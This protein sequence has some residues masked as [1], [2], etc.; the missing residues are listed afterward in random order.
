MKKAMSALPVISAA[1]ILSAG[2]AVPA[3]CD[4]MK[5]NECAAV[6][7]IDAGASEAVILDKDMIEK[8][9]KVEDVSVL[10]VGWA[11]NFTDEDQDD[12][13]T[14]EP[15]EGKG[16]PQETEIGWEPGTRV[17]YV[18]LMEDGVTEADGYLTFF[19]PVI[20]S[21]LRD[22]SARDA[23]IV[24]LTNS[25][26][27]S[28]DDLDDL[29]QITIHIS[30]P[31]LAPDQGVIDYMFITDV[32]DKDIDFHTLK[33]SFDPADEME[34]SHLKYSFSKEN[35]LTC[36]GKI[37]KKEYAN[38]TGSL[39]G[40]DTENEF[41]KYWA[42]IEY[43][44]FGTNEDGTINTDE[45]LRTQVATRENF[46]ELNGDGAGVE[47]GYA[48]VQS[49]PLDKDVVMDY[50]EFH[51]PLVQAEIPSK[52]QE[53]QS[54]I[55]EADGKKYHKIY[56]IIDDEYLTMTDPQFDQYYAEGNAEEGV[57]NIVKAGNVYIN[58]HKIPY[59]NEAGE[60][61]LDGYERGF[62][63]G[64]W[65]EEGG[66][67][68]QAHNLRSWRD[69]RFMPEIEGDSFVPGELTDF[70]TA[71][72]MYTKY[73]SMLRGQTVDLWAEEG[74]DKASLI[75]TTYLVSSLISKIEEQDGIIRMYNSYGELLEPEFPAENVADDVD[76]GDM[77]IFW[78][79]S[80]KG[81]CAHQA[82]KSV[83]H[84][85]ENTDPDD[86]EAIKHPF[87]LEDGAEGTV[88]T[89]DS[90]IEKKIGTA[91][92]HT[93][94]IRGHRRTDQYNV[95]GSIIMWS[96][97]ESEGTVLGFSRGDTAKEALQ[98]SVDYAEEV[99]ADVVVSEDGTDV[100]SDTYWVTSEIWDEF[101]SGLDAAKAML[102]NEETTNLEMDIMTFELGNVLGG[103]EDKNSNGPKFNPPGVV[104][105]ME[106][107][108]KG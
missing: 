54:E 107:G 76:E 56:T 24:D 93:Q 19:Y 87:W 105:S 25:G 15:E 77:I 29:M 102:E 91:F 83:G 39:Q 18:G 59:Q 55:L 23:K 4:Q 26:I 101:Q 63:N 8:T 30:N 94:F 92:T 106:L 35:G 69:D 57:R 1:V 44:Q 90:L 10:N 12:V 34:E 70:E 41:Y 38:Y 27:T 49:A 97:N 50:S 21:E 66:W 48:I 88:S 81:W 73:L 72:F 61:V 60:V 95:D 108:S 20:G 32:S 103:T 51:F 104:G 7:S 99:T 52:E 65:E 96:S 16:P 53:P 89:T 58:G 82:V 47:Y 74:S 40:N 100:A 75:S 5:P 68:W 36:K 62:E 45:A 11:Y 98:H 14:V 78:L 13:F 3:F 86:P 28:V 17:A 84:L 85:V 9:V 31:D 6:V 22:M 79:D 2:M 71:A 43:W 64:I 46:F 80:K 37:S 33:V 67:A 42:K